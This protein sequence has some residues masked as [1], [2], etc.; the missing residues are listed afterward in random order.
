MSIDVAQV[1]KAKGLHGNK[2]TR[3]RV[4]RNSRLASTSTTPYLHYPLVWRPAARNSSNL[5]LDARALPL[6]VVKRESSLTTSHMTS[7]TKGK[8]S[9]HT[10]I[11][12]G[13]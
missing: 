1:Y 8:S 7:Q 2:H 13:S 10:N 9:Q 5:N 3:Y 12:K 4:S 6:G 11:E